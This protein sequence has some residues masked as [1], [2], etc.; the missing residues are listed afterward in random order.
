MA[1]GWFSP[2]LHAGI[3]TGGD[4]MGACRRAHRQQARRNDR[5]T[6]RHHRRAMRVTRRPTGDHQK[7]SRLPLVA[8]NR[9]AEVISRKP[10][11]IA[12][13]ATVETERSMPL[14]FKCAPARTDAADLSESW[15]RSLV[16]ARRRKILWRGG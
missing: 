16:P 2:A 8:K 13:L 11:K 10:H 15:R 6:R 7:P 14:S 5:R 3:A 12:L 1:C 4:A 9:Q